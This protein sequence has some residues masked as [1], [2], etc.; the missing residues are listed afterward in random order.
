MM[1]ESESVNTAVRWRPSGDAD[2]VIVKKVNEKV[3]RV[4]QP[5]AE[6]KIIFILLDR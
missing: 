1:K 2:N 5:T 6:L 3:S 4:F